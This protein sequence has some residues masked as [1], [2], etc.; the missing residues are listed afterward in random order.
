MTYANS[1]ERGALIR[2]LRAF[3]DYLESNSEVPA[4]GYADVLVF[5]PDGTDAERRAEIDV[6]AGQIGETPETI[7]GHYVVSRFFGPV[8]YRAVAIPRDNDTGEE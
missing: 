1:T 2:G 8:Q 7:C 4:P 3:A 5:P 6:I